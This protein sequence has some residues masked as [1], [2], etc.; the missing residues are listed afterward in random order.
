MHE[1]ALPQ[2]ERSR[3]KSF[4]WPKAFF[5][6]VLVI[7]GVALAAFYL[8]LQHTQRLVLPPLTGEQAQGLFSSYVVGLQGRNHLQVAEL[9]TREEF[10][11]SSEKRFFQFI[12][13][14]TVEVTAVVPCEIV[15]HVELKNAEWRFKV[16]DDGRRLIVIA[17]PIGFGKP[18]VDFARYELRVSKSSFIRDAEE[19]KERLQ[20]Q[21]PGFLDEVGRRNVDSVR[22]TARIAIKD[23]I[24]NWLLNSLQG[25]NVAQPVVDRVYFS[26]EGRLYDSILLQSGDSQNKY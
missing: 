25:R 9:K 5:Y 1:E 19:V 24:E 3:G 6:S 4:T 12:P 14:G 8:F 2:P 11:L 21:I 20:S 13:G 26:D 10:G 22:D 17:P 7:F 16:T 23:F 15:Y 18:A